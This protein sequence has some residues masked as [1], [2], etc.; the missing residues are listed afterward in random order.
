MGPGCGAATGEQT[1]HPT[2]SAEPG[3]TLDGGS[4]A[5]GRRRPALVERS[6]VLRHAYRVGV[7]VVGSAIVVV[8]VVLLPAPGPGWLIIF[9]GLG[10]LASEFTWAERLLALA[11]H[12]VGLWT[13]WL[14]HQGIAVRALVVLA[15]MA[16]VLAVSWALFAVSGVPGW[17]PDRV[18]AQLLLVPGL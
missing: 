8:G 11:R 4:P 7:G 5:P 13:A 2:G 14:A 17:L 3:D 10:V 18:R 6:P 12:Q 15:I 16:F 9:V 1:A